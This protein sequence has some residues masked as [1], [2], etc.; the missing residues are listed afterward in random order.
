MRASYW[1]IIAVAVLTAA[2]VGGCGGASVEQLEAQLQ[3]A[4]KKRDEAKGVFIQ[5]QSELV[6]CQDS[7]R[8]FKLTADGRIE[9]L[10][11]ENAELKAQVAQKK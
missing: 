6:G 2:T 4:I 9:E 5:M 11:K 8:V 1:G 3:E 10:K 7:T